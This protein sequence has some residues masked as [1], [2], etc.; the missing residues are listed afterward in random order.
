MLIPYIHS[1]TNTFLV[2]FESF[3]EVPQTIQNKQVNK[4]KKQPQTQ[5]TKTPATH[6][7]V[8]QCEFTIVN[9]YIHVSK[10]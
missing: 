3:K 1:C 2:D 8:L 4:K 5:R 10:Q 6:C 9:E 7:S